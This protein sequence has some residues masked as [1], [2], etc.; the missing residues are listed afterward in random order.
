MLSWLAKKSIEFYWKRFPEKS[1]KICIYKITCSKYVYKEFTNEG[2]ISGLKAFFNRRKS[3]S[4]GYSIRYLNKKVII[5]DRNGLIIQEH[6]I[7]PLIV[8][9]FKNSG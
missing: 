4:N 2:F 5:E 6:E 3:C 8:K 1:R 7:N 9:E